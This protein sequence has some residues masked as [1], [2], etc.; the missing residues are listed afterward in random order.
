MATMKVTVELDVK[1]IHWFRDVL[2]DARNAQEERARFFD[3]RANDR[4][5]GMPEVDAAWQK[6]ADEATRRA[7]AMT[8]MLGA[9]WD[10]WMALG[11]EKKKWGEVIAWRQDNG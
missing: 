7:D 1:D 6:D 10:A 8:G 4:R 11:D 2:S 9:S 5:N 3:L